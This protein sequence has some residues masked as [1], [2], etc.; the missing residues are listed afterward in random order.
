MKVLADALFKASFLAGGRFSN[1]ES[2]GRMMD[3]RIS[4][5]SAP[6]SDDVR[7]A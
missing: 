6:G 7:L 3:S 5:A 4:E 2:S 1:G